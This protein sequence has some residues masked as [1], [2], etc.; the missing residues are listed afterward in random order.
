MNDPRTKMRE[1]DARGASAFFG[2]RKGKQLRSRQAGLMQDFLPR[3]AVDVTIA[4]QN[5]AQ[6]F[7]PPASQ[8]QIEIGFGGAEHLIAQAASNPDIGF[9]GCEAFVNG[10]AKAL[11]R[12]EEREI[13]NIRI[14]PADAM[15]LLRVLPESSIS[16]LF[17][18]YPDPWPKPRQRK[19]RIV[20]KNFLDLAR[21]W[22][23]K[24]RGRAGEH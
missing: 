9:I 1:A 16:K 8:V 17:L 2:R 4:G 18:L 19:R 11:A 23:E 15:E 22:N 5:P 3:Q 20:S 14:F 21:D 12:I 7:N 6:L 13:E 24:R 10:I